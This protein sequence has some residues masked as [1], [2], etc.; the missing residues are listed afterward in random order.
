MNIVSAFQELREAWFNKVLRNNAP[1]RQWEDDVQ[2]LM[3]E[4]DNK[5]CK[6]EYDKQTKEIIAGHNKKIAPH[7]R[8]DV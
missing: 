6:E 3:R 8:N 1:E 4:D 2:E 7:C 5:R